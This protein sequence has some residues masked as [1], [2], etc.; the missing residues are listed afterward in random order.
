MVFEASLC[1]LA[2]KLHI[3]DISK[4]TN[5]YPQDSVFPLVAV[6]DNSLRFLGTGF[7][8]NLGN[9][10]FCVTAE[11]VTRDIEQAYIF[12]V[13]G[14]REEPFDR[15]QLLHSITPHKSDN[16]SDL[17]ILNFCDFEPRSSFGTDPMFDL[18]DPVLM[19]FEYSRSQVTEQ[20]TN[21]MGGL[22][23]GN[24][25]NFL[26]EKDNSPRQLELSFPALKGASGAPVFK[27]VQGD[28]N[29]TE[30][31]AVGVLTCNAQYELEPIQTYKYIGQD[32]EEEITHYYLPAGIATHIEHLHRML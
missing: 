32:G 11:H 4:L 26:R 15:N 27:K 19:T 5:V 7:A 6:E 29:A 14:P 17:A 1:F 20:N 22:R 13:W 2:V 23:Y 18:C 10:T 16:S 9:T 8:A 25:V 28:S 3:E 12:D 30:L 24:C 31:H 21:F